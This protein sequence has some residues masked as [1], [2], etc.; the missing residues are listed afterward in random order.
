LQIAFLDGKINWSSSEIKFRIR[1]RKRSKFI[2]PHLKVIAKS[3]ICFNQGLKHNYSASK[4]SAK[5]I[6]MIIPYR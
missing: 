3:V 2:P 1:F 5:R 4:H 6:L